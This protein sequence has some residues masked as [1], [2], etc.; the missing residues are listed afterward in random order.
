MNCS[1]LVHQHIQKHQ[2]Y[3][4][5]THAMMC[6]DVSKQYYATTITHR[7]RTIEL[8]KQRIIMSNTLSKI[9]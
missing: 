9:W 1:T 7:K 3:H 8:L 2:E 6:S 4:K 5:H